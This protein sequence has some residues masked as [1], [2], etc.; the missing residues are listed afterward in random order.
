MQ[1]GR[2]AQERAPTRPAT[3]G[4]GQSGSGSRGNRAFIPYRYPNGNR[5]LIS[6]GSLMDEYTTLISVLVVVVVLV[7]LIASRI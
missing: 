7:I 4:L 5:D 6:N 1:P 2:D 3:S